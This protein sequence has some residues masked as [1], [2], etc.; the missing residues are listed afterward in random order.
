MDTPK[1]KNPGGTWGWPGIL[2]ELG[3]TGYGADQKH[4]NVASAW[5][6]LCKSAE[7]PLINQGTSMKKH[8]ISA[9]ELLLDAFRL[10][11]LIYQRGFKPNFIVGV[12]RGGAPVGIAVQEYLEF[13]GVH[14]DHI[15][16]RTASYYGID[17]QDKDVKVFGLNYVIDNVKADHS[18]LI[19]DDVFD[20]GRSLKAIIDQIRT[21]AGEH[22]PA[23]IKTAC[24]W[25][26]PSRNVTNLTP[27]FYVHATD[28]WLVFPHELQG[29]TL[30]EII[31][32]KGSEIGDLVYRAM[33]SRNASGN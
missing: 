12:W 23:T 18:L 16:I 8:F 14:A 19:V 2:P 32:G 33:Q 11:E 24:P 3:V 20:S 25:Y 6:I 7:S 27:D 10:A 13:M 1:T 5:L 22:A 30:E 31:E 15:A 9:D 26:K 17:Q 21:R 29:L 28:R 4:H